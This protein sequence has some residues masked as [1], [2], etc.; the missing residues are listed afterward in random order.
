MKKTSR[1]TFPIPQDLSLLPT[2]NVRQFIESLAEAH[3]VKYERTGLDEFAEAVTRL[4][5]DEA[6]LDKTGE[7]LVELKRRQ[8]LNGRQVAPGTARPS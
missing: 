7:L 2:V 6:S 3:G 1:G 8:I 5:G 4:A